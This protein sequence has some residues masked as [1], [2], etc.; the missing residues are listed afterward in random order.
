MNLWKKIKDNHWALMIL[1]CILP[2][3]ALAILIFVFDVRSI[4]L[5]WAAI[6]ICLGS[7]MW[8]MKSMHKPDTKGGGCH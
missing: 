8:M 5:T 1:T 2:F 7:H 4:W 3:A 6:V